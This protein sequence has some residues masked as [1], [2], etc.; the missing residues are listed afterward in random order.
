[1]SVMEVL[2]DEQLEG[3]VPLLRSAGYTVI[4]VKRD[5]PGEEDEKLVLIAKEKGYVFVTE[6]IRAA[7]AAKFHDVK[8]IQ[9]DLALKTKAVKNELDKIIC[10]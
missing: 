1:M 9:I 5:Y 8:Y 4:S 6:D 3:M 10:H 2:V 7:D